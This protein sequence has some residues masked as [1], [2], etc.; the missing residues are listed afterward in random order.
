[1]CRLHSPE[2]HK[3]GAPTPLQRGLLGWRRQLT[4]ATAVDHELEHELL[5]RFSQCQAL[6]TKS[7]RL[8]LPNL[9]WR[10]QAAQ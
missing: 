7:P 3:A 4:Q 10:L 8:E 6:K 5:L 1:M 2:G 9:A